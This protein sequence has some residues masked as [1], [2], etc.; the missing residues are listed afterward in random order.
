MKKRIGIITFWWTQHNYGQMLQVYALQKFLEKKGHDP[1]VIRYIGP[2][3]KVENKSTFLDKLSINNIRNFLTRKF[4]KEKLIK[5]EKRDF[6]AFRSKYL[7]LSDLTYITENEILRN[8]PVADAYIC[9][10]DQIWNDNFGRSLDPY[11]LSFGDKKVKRIA[12]AAS[13][14]KTDFSEDSMKL[15]QKR[16]KAFDAISVR[17]REGIEI[18]SRANYHNAMWVPDPTLLLTYKD[19]DAL[20]SEGNLNK[21][22]ID[23]LT[24]YTFIYTLGNSNMPDRNEFLSYFKKKPDFKSI[25]ISSNTDFSGDCYP[26]IEDW[27][28]LMKNSQFVLTNSFHGMIFSILLRKKFVILPNTGKQKGMNGRI[29]SFL[30]RSGLNDHLMWNY[31]IDQ[32]K[33]IENKEVDWNQIHTMLSNWI[34]ESSDFLL[35]NIN[36][37]RI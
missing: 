33:S 13:F 23:E 21:Y 16:F 24:P 9:G 31:D 34:D 26:S 1:F 5:N 11:L 30:E 22:G 19:W 2:V 3:I 12:Y 4:N 14:G 7:Q 17:E 29:T 18:C 8:P 6:D 28:L 25:H 20:A 15:F 27:L 35:D 32:I 37:E 36:D 10:S